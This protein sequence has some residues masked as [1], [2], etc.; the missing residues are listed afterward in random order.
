MIDIKMK[1]MQNEYIMALNEQK[2]T[3]EWEMT[4]KQRITDD[5]RIMKNNDKLIENSNEQTVNND[6]MIEKC[7]KLIEKLINWLKNVIMNREQ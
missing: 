7:D 2:M 4:K 3:C 5:W 1:I 6:K